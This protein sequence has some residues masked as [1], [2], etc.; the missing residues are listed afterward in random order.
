MIRLTPE[1]V[2]KSAARSRLK[3]WLRIKY[4]ITFTQYTKMI[5]DQ[6]GRCAICRKPADLAV[7]HCHKTSKVR[8]LLCD[9][10]N[11]GLAMFRD[12]PELLYEAIRYLV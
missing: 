8:S 11:T 4:G 5:I 6:A 3:Y 10:C 1:Q 2:K 9:A 7:D 12:D